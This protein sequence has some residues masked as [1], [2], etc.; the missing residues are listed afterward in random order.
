M[1]ARSIRFACLCLIATAGLF[2]IL[3][4][5]EVRNMATH[6]RWLQHDINRPKPPVVEP[7][8]SAA[9]APR[10][11]TPSFCSTEP[12]STPGNPPREAR[13]NGR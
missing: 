6:N 8:A 5:D 12:T 4:A 9:A 3:V 7:A 1:S 13:H 10:P 2:A 11:R